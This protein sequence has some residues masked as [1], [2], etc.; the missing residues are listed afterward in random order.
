MILVAKYVVVGYWVVYVS[1]GIIFQQVNKAQQLFREMQ[2]LYVQEAQKIQAFEVTQGLYIGDASAPMARVHLSFKKEVRE[3]VPVFVPVDSTQSDRMMGGYP[4][5]LQPPLF[6]SLFQYLRFVSEDTLEGRPVWILTVSK[7]EL[8]TQF[9]PPVGTENL[10]KTPE[11]QQLLIYADPEKKRIRK[12]EMEGVAPDHKTPFHLELIYADYRSIEGFTYPFRITILMRGMQEKE[13][14]SE[15][16]ARAKYQL[17]QLERQLS[18]M[19][20]AQRAQ[21][22]NMRRLLEQAEQKQIILRVDA[23]SLTVHPDK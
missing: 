12:V 15:K 8:F 16:L 13:L 21:V 18:S 19:T 10:T 7:P 9:V 14:S 17:K 1:A 2:A 23:Q 11:I 22:E 5:F 6:D 3:G 20:E 4:M